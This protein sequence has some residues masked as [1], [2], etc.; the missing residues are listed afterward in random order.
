[1]LGGVCTPSPYW[2]PTEAMNKT[3]TKTVLVT[4]HSLRVLCFRSKDENDAYCT[5]PCMGCDPLQ[6]LAHLE[7]QSLSAFVH[8][9]PAQPQFLIQ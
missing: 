3:Y 1:M 8:Q 9:G 5:L 7:A 2:M 6:P 4:W